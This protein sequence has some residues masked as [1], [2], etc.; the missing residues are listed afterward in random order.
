MVYLHCQRLFLPDFG[1]SPLTSKGRHCC[2]STFCSNTQIYHMQY[3]CCLFVVFVEEVCS[4]EML[5][6]VNL[7]ARNVF[8]N[9]NWSTIMLVIIVWFCCCCTTVFAC[10][11]CPLLMFLCIKL[12]VDA[13]MFLFC[14]ALLL[15]SSLVLQQNMILFNVKHLQ[16]IFVAFHCRR[17][18]CSKRAKAQK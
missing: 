10:F 4:Q 18:C 15:C 6:L 17:K 7:F 2:V 8:L 12:F 11:G 13:W 3:F 16:N 9:S 5:F 14:V 1:S